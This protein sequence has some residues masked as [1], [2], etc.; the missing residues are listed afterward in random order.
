VFAKVINQDRE[1][2]KLFYQKIQEKI[3]KEKKQLKE[4]IDSEYPKILSW[5]LKGIAV[6]DYNAKQ[7]Q[8][9][10]FSLDRCTYFVE[11]LI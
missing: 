11:K 4:K 8:Q 7:E 9:I 2:K 6:A 3:E 5:L 10:S 1:I